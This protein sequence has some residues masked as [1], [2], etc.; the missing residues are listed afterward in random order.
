M[1]INNTKTIINS[2]PN[3]VK[4]VAVTKN[5]SLE[6]VQVLVNLGINDFGEN[7]LQELVKKKLIFPDCNWHFIGRIQSNKIKDIVKHSCLIHSVSELRYLERINHEASKIN[8]VQD[9]LLQLNLAMEDSKKGLPIEQLEFIVNN[10]ESFENVRICGLMV[11]GNHTDNMTIINQT[12]NE[13]HQVFTDLK[14][15]SSDITTLSMGMSNDYTLAISAGSNLVRIGS[16]L[17]AD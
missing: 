17:F 15:H 10:L 6:D 7:K 16:A 4:L 9:I 2:I 3:D 8:K 11:M 5:Q 14:T 1:N 13:A 12:F